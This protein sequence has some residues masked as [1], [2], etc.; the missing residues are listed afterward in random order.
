V[1]LDA[2][3]FTHPEADWQRRYE[4][5]RASYVERLPA[6]IVANRFNYTPGYV[7]LLRHQFRSGKIDFGEPP[8]EGKASR[9]RVTRELR[10][11]IRS[12]REQRLPAGEIAQLLSEAG[13][14]ISVRTVERILAEEG[15]PKLPRRTALKLGVTVKGAQVPDK[16]HAAAPAD[17][18]GQRFESAGAGVFLFA[19][20][21]AQLDIAGVVRD[22]R[23]P[24]TKALPATSYLLSF[25]AL[26]LLGTE[27]YAHV[28]DHSF[29]QGLGLFCGLN[30]LPMR[31]P[32]NLNG[33]SGPT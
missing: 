26:K 17:L 5:L 15:F 20:F 25:L 23:L 27:R 2:K 6:K 14:E 9:R 29:D 24:G 12:W 4:A 28:G 7:H 22:A 3:Y 11:K 13:V 10:Q 32:A 16:S 21:L 8:I 30:V 1:P 18:D 31:I 33:H 19:P